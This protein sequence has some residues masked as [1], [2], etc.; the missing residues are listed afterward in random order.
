MQYNVGD[1]L[2]WH[3]VAEIRTM[4]ACCCLCRH[5]VVDAKR[6]RLHG[7]GCTTAKVVLREAVR[8]TRSVSR[9]KKRDSCPVLQV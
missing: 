5:R 4:A 6:K 2:S 1:T 9:D 3:F 7:A 8:A